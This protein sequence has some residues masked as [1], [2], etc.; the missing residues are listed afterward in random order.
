MLIEREY[1]KEPKKSTIRIVVLPS[2]HTF[3]TFT[4]T[5]WCNALILTLVVLLI[6]FVLFM[7]FR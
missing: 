4:P 5:Q 1:M 6:A 7:V 2:S 3:S